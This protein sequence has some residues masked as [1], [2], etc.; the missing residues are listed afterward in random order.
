VA[1]SDYQDTCAAPV[2]DDRSDRRDVAIDS[3]KI[4]MEKKLQ[5]ELSKLENKRRE[6]DIEKSFIGRI[7][8]AIEPIFKP[9]GFSWREGV[10]LITGF[11]AKE[12][13]VS[14]LGVLYGAGDNEEGKSLKEALLAKSH[15]TPL[16][17]YAFLVFVLI[18]TPC[19]ATIAAIRRETGSMKWTLFSIGYELS[20]AWILSFLIVHIGRLFIGG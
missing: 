19:L 13:V 9:L 15:M 3:E 18:Y 8:K 17:A 1:A 4:A 16:I 2:V 10:A 5:N 6:E 12:I 14:T 7:G 20:L 11:V